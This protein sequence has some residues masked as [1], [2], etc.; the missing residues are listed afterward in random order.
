MSDIV[1][2][3]QKELIDKSKK[4]SD[5]L[6]KAY[7]IAQ[8]L[9]LK[10][11]SDWLKLEMNGYQ[12]VKRSTIPS[13]RS[14]TGNVKSRN[15]YTGW[16]PL[17]IEDK[18]IKKYVDDIKSNQSIA[19]LEDILENYSNGYDLN[20]PL[21]ELSQFVEHHLPCALFTGRTPL[22]SII[23]FVRNKLL[24]WTLELEKKGIKGENM[25]FLKEDVEK[26]KKINQP[27]ITFNGDVKG[28][29]ILAQ[30]NDTVNQTQNN[31]SESLFSKIWS[32]IK[33]I[34]SNRR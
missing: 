23:N 27:N 6:P 26:A 11:L 17:I 13:Y 8:K 7:L 22:V 15:P 18:N 29:I 19:E 20:V 16:I 33:S 12:N 2:E 24:D 1:I 9:E 4:L 25:E 5:I 14:I 31:R 10:E 34:F 3:L 30:G 28:N 21:P 32:W